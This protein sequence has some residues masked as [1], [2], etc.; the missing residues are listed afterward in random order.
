MDRKAA[1]QALGGHQLAADA[2][3]ADPPAGLRLQRGHEA[4]AELIARGLA[5]DQEN[6]WALSVGGAAPRNHLGGG[7]AHD[8]TASVLMPT[9]K[10]PARSAAFVTAGA[11]TTRVPPASTAMP[12][13]PAAAAPSTVATPMVGRSARRSCPGL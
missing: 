2:G 13:S 5:G 6:E 10:R 4:G 7:V 12:R 3:K 9:R 8:G 1:F 11:S